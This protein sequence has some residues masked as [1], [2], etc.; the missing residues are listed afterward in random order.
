MGA[1]RAQDAHREPDQLHSGLWYKRLEAGT[2]QYPFN[3]S[4]R[5]EIAAWD[6]GVLLEGIDLKAGKRRKRFELSG[7]A[8][9]AHE[10]SLTA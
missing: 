3:A 8:K 7:V 4:G 1:L 2:F 10:A 5:K 9:A 6:L